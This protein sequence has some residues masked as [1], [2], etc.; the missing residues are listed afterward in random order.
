MVHHCTRTGRTPAGSHFRGGIP[1]RALRQRGCEDHRIYQ[2]REVEDVVRPI[3]YAATLAIVCG[4][5]QA[6]NARMLRIQMA[7]EKAAMA[8][9]MEAERAAMVRVLADERAAWAQTQTQVMRSRQVAQTVAQ[10]ERLE[11][12]PRPPIGPYQNGADKIAYEIRHAA[13]AQ[14]R[15]R[16]LEAMRQRNAD[17]AGGF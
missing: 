17:R 7:V 4:A 2:G 12:E 14:N 8:Q 13:W 9:Q 10:T 15:A 5:L 11:P 3:I 16:Q 1:G 6:Y